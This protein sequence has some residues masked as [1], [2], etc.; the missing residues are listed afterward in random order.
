MSLLPTSIFAFVLAL[1]NPEA[2]AGAPRAES[3]DE[4]VVVAS[5]GNLFVTL[6]TQSRRKRRRRPKRRGGKYEVIEVRNGGTIEGVVAYYGPVPEAETIQIVK[7]HE[8]CDHRAKTRRVVKV[9][10]QGRLT[11]VV[12]FLG[13]IKAGKAIPDPE[14]KAMINQR[15]C[16]FD[17]HVQVLMTRQPFD[18]VNGDPVAHNARCV[19][20]MMTL[21]NPMQP[22]QGMRSE[23]TIKRPGLAV[24]TCAVH[25]WMRAFVYVLWHPYYAVSGSDGAFSI[26]DVPP[27]E[28][29]LVAWQE[30]LGERSIKVT[31]EPGKITTLEFDLTEE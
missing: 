15:Y 7:D 31:V 8:T 29:E 11:E 22:K 2:A 25:D 23:F 5:D 14:Q 6:S 24:I 3:S 21:F 18:I 9:N 20:N 10:E 1:P 13:D 26:T 28:Y 17:P 16:T 27:G 4:N 19:Q 30:H 12:V